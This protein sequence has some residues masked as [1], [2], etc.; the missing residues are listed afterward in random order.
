MGDFFSARRFV[1]TKS[2]L[3]NVFGSLGR[4]RNL[5]NDRLIQTSLT[6]K[7]RTCVPSRRVK[8]EPSIHPTLSIQRS[9]ISA[10]TVSDIV[11]RL[12]AQLIW[13][14]FGSSYD[15]RRLCV[16]AFFSQVPPQIHLD[17]PIMAAFEGK[18]NDD[19]FC[20]LIRYGHVPSRNAFQLRCTEVS[21]SGQD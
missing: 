11:Q 5:L 9:S 14:R 7:A 20:F 1:R 19:W 2:R 4:L 10:A 13:I 12:Y 16:F 21:C 3:V 18:S 17:Q 8:A 6:D 15:G